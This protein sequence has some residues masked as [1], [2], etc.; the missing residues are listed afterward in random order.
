[1]A[2]NT[3]NKGGQPTSWPPGG[4]AVE[5]ETCRLLLIDSN[6]S[7]INVLQQALEK[8]ACYSIDIVRAV[9]LPWGLKR[10]AEGGIDYVLLDFTSRETAGA[11]AIKQLKTQAPETPIIALLAHGD[12]KQGEEALRLGADDWL[13]KNEL[14]GALLKHAFRHI[15]AAHN[16]RDTLAK[17]KDDYELHLQKRTEFL[18]QRDAALQ[19]EMARR[20]SVEAMGS[21]SSEELKALAAEN[22][23]LRAQIDDLQRSAANERRQPDDALHK[24][25]EEMQDRCTELTVQLAKMDET[26]EVERGRRRRAEEALGSALAGSELETR[27]PPRPTATP[28]PRSEHLTPRPDSQ[29]HAQGQTPAPDG[30]SATE[31]KGSLGSPLKEVIRAERARR[32]REEDINWQ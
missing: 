16:W 19:N 32:K 24:V 1:M 15:A 12:T 27:N 8:S 30:S 7:D 9:K 23:A 5:E 22:S 17:T 10:L 21:K 26:L 29:T 4:D 13:P 2:E 31:H 6:L 14:S 3:E 20:K 11:D 18:A 28:S 25:L